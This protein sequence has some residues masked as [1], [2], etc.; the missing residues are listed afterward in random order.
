MPTH[1]NNVSSFL[2]KRCM[3]VSTCYLILRACLPWYGRPLQYTHQGAPGLVCQ[4]V[5]LIFFRA[6][7]VA[8][9]KVSFITSPALDHLCVL[10]W[11]S[12]PQAD[13]V[14]IQGLI[15][16][17][18]L[19]AGSPVGDQLSNMSKYGGPRCR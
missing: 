1:A 15:S 7:K 4:L 2:Q 18:R 14:T 5:F 6:P 10:P 9:K 3:F 11:C 17:A 19:S 12:S 16:L 13:A 8:D